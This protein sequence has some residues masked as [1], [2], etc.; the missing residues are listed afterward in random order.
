MRQ[1]EQLT[2]IATTHSTMFSVQNADDLND[3]IASLAALSFSKF[4]AEFDMNGVATGAS[5]DACYGSAPSVIV[6]GDSSRF[7]VDPSIR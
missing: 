3:I 1:E 4:T 6:G 2:Q 7:L 5:N